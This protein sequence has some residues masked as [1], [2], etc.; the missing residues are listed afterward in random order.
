MTHGD[1]DDCCL[2]NVVEEWRKN[3][4]NPHC[5]GSALK[6]CNNELWCTPCAQNLLIIV[7]TAFFQ[8]RKAT[9]DVR[10]NKNIS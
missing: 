5:T 9:K 8:S 3:C 4:E 10:E 6:M 2:E 7:K 1:E